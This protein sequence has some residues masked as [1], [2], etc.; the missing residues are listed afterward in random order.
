MG[1][2]SGIPGG[3]GVRL[4]VSRDGTAGYMA[5]AGLSGILSTSRFE[6]RANSLGNF[7]GKV[8][9][10]TTGVNEGSLQ[11]LATNADGS[12]VWVGYG[13]D[14]FMREARY[15]GSKLVWTAGLGDFVLPGNVLSNG[16][17][18]ADI[19]VDAYGKLF[20]HDQAYDLRIHG[21]AG[22][23]N[24][25]WFNLADTALVSGPSGSMRISGD[26]CSL[27]GN[28]RLMTIQP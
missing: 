27:I 20:T 3:E 14:H 18:P 11:D 8:V 26:G 2:L 7:Y 22:T 15:D 25:E 23:L 13:T 19:E 17:G 5:E 21:P 24:Q 1:D 6:L 10:V 16:M 28:G 9:A 4:G 12:R